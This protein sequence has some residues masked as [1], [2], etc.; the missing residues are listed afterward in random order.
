MVCFQ[1]FARSCV[2]CGREK[3][4][5]EAGEIGRPTTELRAE[6]AGGRGV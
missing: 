2:A 5:Q 6:L 1:W 4:R 3:G